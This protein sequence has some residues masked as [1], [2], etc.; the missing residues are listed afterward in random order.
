MTWKSLTSVTFVALSLMLTACGPESVSDDLSQLATG[1][2]RTFEFHG[3]PMEPSTD[4][5]LDEKGDLVTVADFGGMV[6]LV[7]VWATWCAPC[8]REM[9]QL[10]ALAAELGREEFALI[11]VSTDRLVA[12][13]L[14]RA[15]IEEFLYAEIGATHIPLYTD[16]PLAFAISSGVSVWPTTILYDRDGFEIGRINGPAEWDGAD[17][18][19]LIEGVIEATR[20]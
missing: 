1:D 4:A 12:G 20:P 19:A 6:L 14:T 5:F 17:A 16:W 13:G 18:R 2:M 7:N 8:V 15:E 10:D 9:P 11:A 3:S